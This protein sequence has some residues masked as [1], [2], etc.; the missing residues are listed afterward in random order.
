MSRTVKLA[1]FNIVT[2]PHSSAG[3]ER[4]FQDARLLKQSIK[5]RGATHAFLAT[6]HNPGG[7]SETNFITG[8]IY[9]FIELDP[10]LDWFDLGDPR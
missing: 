8:E 10:N 3:Y 7:T 5:V 2:H 6:A 4:L 1:A 9:T